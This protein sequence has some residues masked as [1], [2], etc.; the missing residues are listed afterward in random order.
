[1]PDYRISEIKAPVLADIL[2][3][4]AHPLRLQI[5]SVLCDSNMCVNDLCDTLNVRQAHVSQHLTPLRHLGLVSV[6]RTGG[7]ATYSLAEPQLKQLIK[8]LMSCEH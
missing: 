1:M 2:K 6:D 4:L 5:I 3:G 7:K 8:C